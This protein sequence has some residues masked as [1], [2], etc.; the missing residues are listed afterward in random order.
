MMRRTFPCNHQFVSVNMESS[1]EGGEEETQEAVG[2]HQMFKCHLQ[3]NQQHQRQ[4]EE[5]L[6][7]TSHMSWNQPVRGTC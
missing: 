7:G 3:R 1:C 2:H 6:G 4:L 5:L